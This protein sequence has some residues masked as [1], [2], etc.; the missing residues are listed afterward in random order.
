M[1]MP[2]HSKEKLPHD[3]GSA[4]HKRETLYD[5]LLNSK[6]CGGRLL[7]LALRIA[8]IRLVQLTEGG[9]CRFVPCNLGR[10]KV[11]VDPPILLEPLDIAAEI[12]ARHEPCS[13]QSIFVG[14][15]R[16]NIDPKYFLIHEALG[17]HQT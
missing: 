16:P 12:P 8:I 1:S 10:L 15:N 13:E 7:F 2:H 5:M 11:C 14:G 17:A 3:A 6:R 9:L 4:T